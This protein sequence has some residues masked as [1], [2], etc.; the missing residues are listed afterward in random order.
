MNAV[1]GQYSVSSTYVLPQ[2]LY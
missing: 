2:G 1:I